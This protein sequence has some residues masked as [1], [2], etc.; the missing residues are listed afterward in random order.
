MSKRLISLCLVLVMALSFAVP[1]FGAEETAL[2]GDELLAVEE[3]TEEPAEE[4]AEEP[5]EEPA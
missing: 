1:A 5:T 3:P 4:P 2:V